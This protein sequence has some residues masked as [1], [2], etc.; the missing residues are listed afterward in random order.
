MTV[1]PPT[2][3]PSGTDTPGVLREVSYSIPC[4]GSQPKTPNKGESSV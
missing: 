1:E 2:L 3:S 4:R